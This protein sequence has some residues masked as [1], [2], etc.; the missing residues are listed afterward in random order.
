MQKSKGRVI[1][2]IFTL[3]L[4]AA[5]LLS[6]S[7]PALAAVVFEEDFAGTVIDPAKWITRAACAYGNYPYDDCS[8]YAEVTQNESLSLTVNRGN[9]LFA[10]AVSVQTFDDSVTAVEC[11]VWQDEV[12]SWQD[13][14][15]LMDTPLAGFG[16]YNYNNYWHAHW[17]NTL[18]EFIRVTNLPMPHLEPWQRFKLRVQVSGDELQ[19]MYDLGDGAGYRVVYSTTDFSLPFLDKDAPVEE[20]GKLRFRASDQ[21]TTYVDNVRVESSAATDQYQILD[22]E[23]VYN[24]RHDNFDNAYR[25]FSE[26]YAE[27]NISYHGVP[28][29]VKLDG[30]NVVSTTVPGKEEILFPI[31][32]EHV[33]GI[34]MLGVGTYLG[35]L[36][37]HKQSWCDDPTH[38]WFEIHYGDGTS[39]EVFPTDNVTGL[40]RWSDILRGDGGVESFPASPIGYVH[41]YGIDVQD[42]YVDH[43]VMKDNHDIAD[44]TVLAMT[45]GLGSAASELTQITL[46]SPADLVDLTSPPTFVWTADGGAENVFAVDLHIPGIMPF[47]STYNNLHE[48]IYGT[49]WTMP[50]DLW[51]RVPSGMP[52]Y[53]RVRGADLGTEPLSIIISD[54]VRWFNK[55]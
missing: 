32:R 40:E 17:R 9:Y 6:A 42:K 35:D 20:T 7:M 14:P 38:F 48:V 23:S 10:E 4:V 47:W 12:S 8:P 29:K 22:L 33:N 49:S 13:W 45:L 51:D 46:Q 39:E 24:E 19:W 44:Y 25:G 11:E 27:E 43:I 15:F 55:Q 31:H 52:V 1:A 21:R 50:A 28:F 37:G 2:G 54:E 18:G 26:Y 3:V 53:W 5:F 36:F 34:Y 16:Y 41:L 30:N